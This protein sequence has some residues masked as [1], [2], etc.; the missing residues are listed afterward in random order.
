MNKVIAI[1]GLFCYSAIYFCERSSVVERCPDKTEV[2]G[3]IPSARTLSLPINPSD[4][5]S[6]SSPVLSC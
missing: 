6:S 5:T 4:Q 1:T 2:E 3:S